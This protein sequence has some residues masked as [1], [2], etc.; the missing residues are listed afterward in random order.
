MLRKR[1]DTVTEK[2]AFDKKKDKASNLSHKA[3]DKAVDLR[4]QAAKKI[5]D[6]KKGEPKKE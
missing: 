6:M 3:A 4:D 1:F 5:G 2:T